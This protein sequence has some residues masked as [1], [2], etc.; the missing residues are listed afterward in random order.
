MSGPLFGRAL[1]SVPLCVC[2]GDDSNGM[3]RRRRKK[4]K[5]AQMIRALVWGGPQAEWTGNPRGDR[6]GEKRRRKGETNNNV[7]CACMHDR[8]WTGARDSQ[9]M[10][11]NPCVGEGESECV[12]FLGCMEKKRERTA[13]RSVGE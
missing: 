9:C 11:N 7:D 2:F 3:E 13:R 5:C 6:K 1:R 8:R 10:N 4:M 12:G